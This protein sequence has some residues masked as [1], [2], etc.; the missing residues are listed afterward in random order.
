MMM[1]EV[2][3]WV[4]RCEENTSLLPC[5]QYAGEELQVSHKP[6]CM[7]LNTSRYCQVGHE[8]LEEASPVC[9]IHMQ[10]DKVVS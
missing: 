4:K 1:M 10:S 9:Y 2:T 7:T 3:K 5:K 8:A 6:M